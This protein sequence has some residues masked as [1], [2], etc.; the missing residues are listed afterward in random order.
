MDLYRCGVAD[1]GHAAGAIDRQ[2][3]YT[4]RLFIFIAA[5]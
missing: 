4:I 1:G 2:L 5:I 3:F